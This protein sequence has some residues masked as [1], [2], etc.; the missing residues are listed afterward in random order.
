[1][2]TCVQL[3]LKANHKRAILS[4]PRA[5]EERVEERPRSCEVPHAGGPEKANVHRSRSSTRGSTTAT[6]PHLGTA[7]RR[8]LFAHLGLLCRSK[9]RPSVDDVYKP[10]NSIDLDSSRAFAS[11]E[12]TQQADTEE[13]FEDMSLPFFPLPPRSRSAVSF[14]LSL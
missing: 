4:Q 8:R 1:M 2:L 3:K 10:R 9:D 14:S 6:H 11:H 7:R 12:R 5:L 13:G